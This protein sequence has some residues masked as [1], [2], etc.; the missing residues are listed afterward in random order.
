MKL[1]V[2]LRAALMCVLVVPLLIDQVP[3]NA[4]ERDAALDAIAEARSD[5]AIDESAPI[6]EDKAA[7]EALCGKGL[8]A[9]PRAADMT[10][11]TVTCTKDDECPSSDRCRVIDP[12]AGPAAETVFANDIQD[13]FLAAAA[14]EAAV[15]EEPTLAEAPACEAD[16]DSDCG[17]YT[18]NL[19]VKAVPPLALCDPFYEEQGAILSDADIQAMEAQEQMLA[20]AGVVTDE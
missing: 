4:T 10:I 9:W 16:N 19:E 2:T 3:A 11:C 20:A 13:Q 12:N 1:H 14:M 15:A 5:V 6:D 8:I 17:E 18:G 7:E